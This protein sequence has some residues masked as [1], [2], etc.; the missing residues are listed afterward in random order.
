MIH[1]NVNKNHQ[2]I[3]YSI[4]RGITEYINERTKHLNF[5][6]NGYEDT[7]C[8]GQGTEFFPP[9]Y[10]KV[11]I[12]LSFHIKSHE[13]GTLMV[14]DGKVRFI[15]RS[16]SLDTEDISSTWLVD[17]FDLHDPEVFDKLTGKLI[18]ALLE[19]WMCD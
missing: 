1:D 11:D 19:N 6:I 17:D 8:G 16:D 13:I 9:A 5:I 3:E 2:N 18:D 7:T 15:F 10:F 4:L 14:E 12:R